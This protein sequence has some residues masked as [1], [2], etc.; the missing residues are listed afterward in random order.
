[1][2]VEEKG[3]ARL[4]QV[5]KKT[6]ESEPLM[7]CRKV[8]RRCQ[9][10]EGVIGPGLG[11]TKT[12]LRSNW[13]RHEG[14]VIL[15]QALV[16]NVGTCRPDAKGEVQANSLRKNE[17]TDA[18]HRDGGVVHSREEGP[19]MG[20]DRRNASAALLWGQP[21]KGSPIHGQSETVLHCK[22]KVWE[23]YK[24]VKANRGAA[25]SRWPIDYGIRERLE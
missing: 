13:H 23:A 11:R 18:G 15:M 24:R 10:R 14:G 16:R 4:R 5:S 19:V 9:N 12:C 2:S 7:T 3:G 20:S 17:S 25:G 1:M 6:N 8:S 21:V 22:A